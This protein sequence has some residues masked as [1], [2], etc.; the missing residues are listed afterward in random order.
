MISNGIPPVAIIGQYGNTRHSG[1]LEKVGSYAEVLILIIC[2]PWDFEYHE[3]RIASQTWRN[4]EFYCVN[5][6]WWQAWKKAMMNM[7]KKARQLQTAKRAYDA[8]LTARGFGAWERKVSA[9]RLAEEHLKINLI[10]KAFTGF[11]WNRRSQADSRLQLFLDQSDRRLRRRV[12]GGSNVGG[13]LHWTMFMAFPWISQTIDVEYLWVSWSVII[14]RLLFAVLWF[15][16]VTLVSLAIVNWIVSS[17]EW[18][19]CCPWYWC[20]VYDWI[21]VWQM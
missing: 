4:E 14:E 6:F 7:H 5:I 18:H 17:L 20:I 10:G 15:L 19:W 13:W 16:Q 9:R 21:W 8:S 12:L 3:T 2:L 1:M 11:C